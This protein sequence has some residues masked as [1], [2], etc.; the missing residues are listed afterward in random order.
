[1]LALELFPFALVYC[2]YLFIW[3]IL[4]HVTILETF[5]HWMLNYVVLCF[6]MIWIQIMFILKRIYTALC[7]GLEISVEIIN[8]R[9]ELGGGMQM[10]AGYMDAGL[11]LSISN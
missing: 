2:A 9:E 3:L 4:Q 1:R 10:Q 7:S 5:D 11:I 8:F 6:Y